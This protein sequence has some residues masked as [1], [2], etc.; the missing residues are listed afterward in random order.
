MTKM[1]NKYR[2]LVR[3]WGK[4]PISLTLALVLVLMLAAAALAAAV[5]P[6][7]IP[8]ASNVGKECAA[9][10]PDVPDILEFKID[11]DDE[12]G[13]VLESGVY[14]P[15][16]F[17]F[18]VTIV[19]PSMDP[20]S[21]TNQSFDWTSNI[22]VLG[23]VV[24]D[25]VDGANFYNYIQEDGPGPL[26]ADDYLTT[27]G[28]P[29]GTFKGI[30][31]VSF[32]Y[33]EVPYVDPEVTKTAEG[34]YDR[35]VTWELEKFVN[36]DGT[37]F[38]Q[39]TG[40]AGD[41]FPTDWLIFVEKFEAE[42]NFKVTGTITIENLNDFDLDFTIADMLDDGTV[43][44]VTCPSSTVPANDSIV[45]T[46]EA[47]P[48][49]RTATLNTA[50]VSVEGE[51][52]VI[53]EAAVEFE[54][55]LIGVDEGTLTDSRFP[56]FEATVIDTEDFTIPEMFICST[57]PS[58]YS[59]GTYTETFD[60]TAFLNDEINLDDDASVTL[61]CNLPA[62]LVEKTA[63]G[64]YDRTVEW[65]LIKNVNIAGT[66]S[67]EYTG[68]AGDEFPTDWLIFVEKTVILDNYKVE[69]TITIDNPAP[70]PQSFSVTDVLDDNTI[71]EVTCPSDVVLA[72][73][74]VV[75]TYEAFPEDDSATLNT[76]TVSAVGNQD[77]IATAAVAF[78]ETLI[79]VDEGTLTDSRFP[80]FEEIVN[81]TDDFILEETFECSAD[82]ADYTAGSYTETFE[83]V[84]NLN[85]VI[86]LED[87]ASVTLIC[88]L[89]ALLV[90]KTAFG[91]YDRTVEWD[92]IKNVNIAGTNSV[93][94]TGE[95]GDE[96]PTDWLIFVDKTV[97]LDNY[98]VEGTITI[99]NP[100]PIQQHVIVSDTLNDNDGTV[101]DVDCPS[102]IVPAGGTLV[103]TY[104]AFPEDDSAT[105]NIARVDAVGNPHVIAIAEVEFE[106]NL[107]G[108]DE[109]TL[110]DSRF[111]EFEEIVNDTDDFILEETFE[112]SADPAD[113]TD[114][115][116]TDTF[117]NFANLN[118]VIDLEDD[119]S[120]TLI[121]T[122]PALEVEKT[123][124]GSYD[125]TVEWD[126]IKNVNIAGT[127]SVEYTGEA[128]EEFPTDW[129]IFVTKTEVVDNFLVEGTITITNPAEVTQ[130]I[131]GVTDVLSDNTI[132]EVTCP[133]DVVP[134]GGQVVCTYEAFPEDDSATLNTA[135]VSAV[136][137]QDVIATAA[138]A[139]EETLIGVDE[140]TLTDSRFPDFLEMVSSTIDF[141]LPEI[142]ECSTDPA[143]YTAGTYTETFENVAYLNDVIDLDD[144]ASVTLICT[145]P[146]L[147]VEKTAVGS[148][149]RTVTWDLDKFVNEV[150]Q[151]LDE[152]VGLPGDAFPTDWLIFVTKTEVESNFKV[153][154]TITID[155]PAGIP[156]SFS[157]TDVLND[158]TVAVVTCPSL[159]V[160]AG[161]QVVCTYEA[162]PNNAAATLNTATVSAVGN[163]PVPATA[164]VAFEE[165]L[166][167]YDQGTLTDDRFPLF[168][169]IVTG[170]GNFELTETF[171]CP[172]SRDD[173]YGD[174][175][176][177]EATVVNTAFLNDNIELQDSATITIYCEDYGH[178]SGFKWND[179]NADGI[180]QKD[181][182]P[183]LPG[184]EIHLIK[185]DDLSM[186]TTDTDG[187]GF[188]EFNMVLPGVD[189]AVCEVLEAGYVQ[190][191]PEDI[192]EETID[193][194]QFG[195][196]Y[197]PIGYLIN[198]EPGEFHEDNNFGNYKP[199]GCCYTQ[200]Y[201]KTHSAYG[202][203][204]PYDE[205]W[206]LQDG[207]DAEFFTTGYSWYEIFWMPPARGN[208]YIILAH[209]YMAAWLNINNVDPLKAAD[210]TLVADT[211]AQ[212]KALL[213]FYAEELFITADDIEFSDNDRALAIELA[214]YLDM[215]NNGML[216]GGPPHCD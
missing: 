171:V 194:T 138:V 214:S 49:G 129:L 92:L 146:A 103:C 6:I 63:F 144:D 161:E 182:E 55:T 77:V 79:G 195:E 9:V 86:D 135:T 4:V 38:V 29:E 82:P 166:I 168:E 72:G 164:A 87:D 200:G 125:R 19:S 94:Y 177:Y 45:C 80:E 21:E 53:A 155:N 35:T 190:S 2:Y 42:S 10:F 48:D 156:Q 120:V 153:T 213:A 61:I 27:P 201:W 147:E 126:L 145:L 199:L 107:I 162:F 1:K 175:G 11:V 163:D 183:V 64:S 46:Y 41:T 131:T 23:V 123:A 68:E 17:D 60:N 85:D 124:V 198:L 178:K 50:T 193:C 205:T 211:M 3:R 93:E 84:A 105:L 210:P 58:E 44:D 15:G 98:K 65:D 109:G 37:N 111:P 47:L 33:L 204:G 142:F 188:Y 134:A 56:E 39:Y 102:D 31:H 100:A 149:D 114:G 203:A 132:A 40:E 110:T 150:D 117:V 96:F 136:G 169:E 108:V 54:E 116:Y 212:A 179:L 76:A 89:P 207:G 106:E 216:P 5:D 8:G 202:P 113:Y 51:E 130:I 73:G 191:F 22:P 170:T 180:W 13:K 165:N 157:V 70:I 78:E 160:P 206:D 88:N 28:P 101:A 152:Y 95:A 24:K 197:G 151:K 127:N 140:G 172:V 143:D 81:D 18:I 154:G 122:L 174:D 75:C 34:T 186:T 121:C 118:D 115:E 20:D 208:A 181:I 83:N 148:Y 196:D 52:D 209:Q 26:L 141:T 97:I 90:E 128:G 57:D 32:C 66:N 167:G 71:A 99:T 43:A 173:A 59:D 185:L 67:V 7:R 184:W 176:I 133:S 62:L 189:Y 74:Q 36:E 25:G 14:G 215:Y 158:N 187:D 69:G 192:D 139:F 104:E 12:D 30:S 16:D 112:C 137:N 91:S 119:A 159:T